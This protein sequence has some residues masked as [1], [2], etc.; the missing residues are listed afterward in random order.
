MKKSRNK[1][2]R[3]STK[4]S[5]NKAPQKK[6]DIMLAYHLALY[7]DILGQKEKIRELQDLPTDDAKKE[8]VVRILKE[9]AGVVIGTRNLFKRYFESA[10]KEREVPSELP[11]NLQA[12]YLAATRAEVNFRKFSDSLIITV[13]L[14]NNNEHCTPMNGVYFALTSACVMLLTCLAAK[15]PIRGG[16]DVGVCID[17]DTDEI[18]GAA[19]ER[20]YTLESKFA[21]YPRIL[22]GNELLNYLNMI[23][24]QNPKTRPGII[25]K[26]LA[27]K[28]LKLIIVDS[29]GQYML[30]FLH[31]SIWEIE[32]ATYN[33][34]EL[35]IKPAYEFVKENYNIYM[36]QEKRKLG[37]RYGRLL[38]YF[39]IHLRRLGK[40]DLMNEINNV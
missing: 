37:S 34:D 19:I 11:K 3:K 26:E 29:D 27:K 24:N 10:L 17:I 7:F 38:G 18:Y 35:V 9:T 13:P 39:N 15:H 36:Q 22:I 21:D 20:A 5:E 32:D 23:S 4:R 33:F 8:E 31:E 25:A 1:N 40:Q 12:E 6:D 14:H 30:H 2:K 28:C 16:I